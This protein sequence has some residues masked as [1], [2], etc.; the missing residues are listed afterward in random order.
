MSLEAPFIHHVF[1]RLRCPQCGVEENEYCINEYG[2]RMLYA[3]HAPRYDPGAS[4]T[5]E[6]YEN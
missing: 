1:L 4:V 3:I 6:K 5:D 2:L